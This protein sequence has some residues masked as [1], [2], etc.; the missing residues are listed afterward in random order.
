MKALSSQQVTTSASV[1]YYL[2]NIL[3]NFLV[4]E[5]LKE[6]GKRPLALQLQDAFVSSDQEKTEALQQ[7]GDYSL[8][9]SG[10]FSDSLNRK[11]VDVD[12][13]I[14]IGEIAY[15]HLS[16]LHRK[17]ERKEMYLELSANF[18]RFV[19]VLSEVSHATNLSTEHSDL[20]RLYE[21]WLRT[22]SERL[23]KLLEEQGISPISGLE[24][25]FKQV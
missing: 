14:S 15:R 7:L 2:V 21:K 3:L 23:K 8:Y 22:K 20:L 25:I 12:Y 9:I 10:F 5:P 13:Y 19:D 4:S 16:G 11:L 18:I 6:S 1:E 17:K 24:T